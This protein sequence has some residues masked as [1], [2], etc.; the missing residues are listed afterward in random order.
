MAKIN[1]RKE[2]GN[3]GKLYILKYQMGCSA[4][5]E[6]PGYIDHYVTG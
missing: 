5:T 6:E 3:N 4:E 2:K 1:H